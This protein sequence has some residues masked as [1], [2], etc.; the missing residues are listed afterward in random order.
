MLSYKERDILKN[1]ETVA[2]AVVLMDKQLREELLINVDGLQSKKL[3]ENTY[4]K[5]QIDKR[6]NGGIFAVRDHICAMIYS[7]L[8]SGASWNRV[9]PGIDF[10][11]GR[12]THVDEIFSMYDVNI[13]LNTDPMELVDKVKAQTL[14]TQYIKSQMYALIEVN[15]RQML[16][17]EKEYGS[18][19]NFYQHF[20]NADASLNTLVLVLST[21]DSKYKYAQMGEALIAEYLRNVGYDISKPDRHIRRILGS[22]I[23]GCSNNEIVPIYE[24]FDIV[25]EIA[26]ATEKRIAE[27]DYILWS[28]C[29]NGYGEICTVK[30]PKCKS[31][32]NKEICN[33]GK[34]K[35]Y[36]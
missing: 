4:I 31:C 26:K 5:K 21:N 25:A 35:Y 27:V 30:K 6:E 20:I 23:L 16:S 1:I 8:T 13:L 9:E 19:D 2:N 17:L 7:M 36:G 10:D 12:I 34:E 29:A 28:Y 3:W 15:I 18:I 24:T 11:T 22:K 14:G 33:N 32:V